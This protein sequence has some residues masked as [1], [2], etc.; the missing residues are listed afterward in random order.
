MGKSE[1]P[2][3]SKYEASLLNNIANNVIRKISVTAVETRRRAKLVESPCRVAAQPNKSEA[4]VC[5][6]SMFATQPSFDGSTLEL[7]HP[8]LAS[9]IFVCPPLHTN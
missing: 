3:K 6:N 7:G 8:Y 1:Y 4:F 9:M 5:I 2:G